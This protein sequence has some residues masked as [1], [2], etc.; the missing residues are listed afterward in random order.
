MPLHPSVPPG[1][2]NLCPI[3]RGFIVKFHDSL[4]AMSRGRSH[5]CDVFASRRNCGNARTFTPRFQPPSPA[6]TYES[7]THHSSFAD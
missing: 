4:I 1:K 5:P 6:P 3:H 7:Q 2:M